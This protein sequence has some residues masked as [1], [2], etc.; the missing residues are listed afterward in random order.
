[1]F[2]EKI[3]EPTALALESKVSTRP[4]SECQKQSLGPLVITHTQT[5]AF[6]FMS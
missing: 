1:M 2:G 5:V 4:G 3:L 6:I